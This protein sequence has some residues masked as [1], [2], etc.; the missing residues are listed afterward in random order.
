[1]EVFLH[2]CYLPTLYTDYP[3]LL[4]QEEVEVQV[5]VSFVFYFIMWLCN[6]YIPVIINLIPLYLPPMCMDTIPLT[7]FNTAQNTLN[8]YIYFFYHSD[9]WA[10]LI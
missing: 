5:C 1:M 10:S 8:I 7:I 4:E 3:G 2:I 6:K 9:T